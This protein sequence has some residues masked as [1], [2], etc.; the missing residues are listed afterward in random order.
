MSLFIERK[1]IEKCFKLADKLGSF[2]N[3]VVSE[4]NLDKFDLVFSGK[5]IDIIKLTCDKC[6]KRGDV[7]S[8][9]VYINKMCDALTDLRVAT[10]AISKLRDDYMMLTESA[11]QRLDDKLCNAY[12]DIETLRRVFQIWEEN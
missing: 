12:S 9:N 1:Y 6:N 11:K 7:I 5:G 4:Q 2:G 8:H 10:V 3:E